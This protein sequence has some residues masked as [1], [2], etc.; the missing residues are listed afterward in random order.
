MNRI[1]FFL[2]P[3]FVL[4]FPVVSPAAWQEMDPAIM[5][6]TLAARYGMAMTR[7]GGDQVLMF[8]GRYGQYGYTNQTWL[9]DLSTNTWKK[10][11]PQD[12]GS[13]PKG[14][15]FGYMAPVG[16]DQALFFGGHDRSTYF[17]E[18]WLFDLSENMWTKLNPTIEGDGWTTKAY[19]GIAPLGN[20]K[21][22]MFGG[23]KSGTR[24]GETW[25]FDLGKNK[26][27]NM[28]PTVSGGDL[29]KRYGMTLSSIGEG[30]VIGYGG[31]DGAKLSETWLYD[32]ATNTWSLLNPTII[33][34]T[35]QPKTYVG[36]DYI[37]GDRVVQLNAPGTND[38]WIF[39]LS[40]NTWTKVDVEGGQAP[41]PRYHQ[42]FSAVGSGKLVLF[43][44]YI[45]GKYLN[46]TWT[47]QLPDYPVSTLR[48]APGSNGIT[49]SWQQP[50][51]VTGTTFYLYKNNQLISPAITS[52]TVEDGSTV[53]TYLDDTVT[54]GTLNRYTLREVNSVTNTE[55]FSAE[56]VVP[57]CN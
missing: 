12:N 7:I 11:N 28:N 31:Y 46:D 50:D 19:Y 37:G 29:T 35:L 49:I 16:D 27:T 13:I 22:I 32:Y 8:G 36:L 4:L 24:Y 45:N 57:Y 39:D 6:G 5:N 1:A 40:D 54:S 43:G 21:V 52:G 26:W 38:L 34:G 18:T 53:F 2:F 42:G 3:F 48:A 9:Y 23:N 25:V 56:I 10:L 14:R 41:R 30:K 51:E 17:G 15:V 20:G 55:V 33:G 44:G 47:L